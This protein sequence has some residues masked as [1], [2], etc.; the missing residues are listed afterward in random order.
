MKKTNNNGNGHDADN[1]NGI[2]RKEH[3]LINNNNKNNQ[4]CADLE[5]CNHG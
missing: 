3:F 4:S 2:T 5:R 1:E